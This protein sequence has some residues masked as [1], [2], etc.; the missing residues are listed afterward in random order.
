MQISTIHVVNLNVLGTFG[1]QNLVMMTGNY[2]GKSNK[3]RS[4]FEAIPWIM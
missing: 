4:Q 1:L 2:H 3:F